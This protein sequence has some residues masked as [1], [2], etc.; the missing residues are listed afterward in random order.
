MEK[1]IL[2]NVSDDGTWIQDE[3]IDVNQGL[4]S[5]GWIEKKEELNTKYYCN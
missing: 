3:S 5:Q 2:P 4:K 1:L